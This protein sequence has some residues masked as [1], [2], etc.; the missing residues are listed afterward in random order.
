[1]RL[2]GLRVITIILIVLAQ[3]ALHAIDVQVE[4]D[5]IMFFWLRESQ[6]T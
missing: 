1:M 4:I 6:A 5:M 3:H 2:Q